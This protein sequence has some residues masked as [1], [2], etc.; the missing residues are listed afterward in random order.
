MVKV[1]EDMTGWIMSEHGF[2][3]SRLSIIRQAEDYI[4]P[5][6]LHY[7]QWWCSCSCGNSGNFIRKGADIRCGDVQSCG[8]LRVDTHKKY[9]RVVLN[10]EDE[11]GEYGIG[12]CSNTDNEFYF[13]MDDYDKIKEYCWYEVDCGEYHTMEAYEKTTQ[14]QIKMHWLIVG[15]HYDHADRNPF[16]NRKYNLRKAT[17]AQNSAN[18]RILKRNTSGFIGLCWEEKRNKWKTSICVNNKRINLGRFDNKED[19]I[20]ARLRAEKEYFGEFAPQ[21]HLFNEYD[22]I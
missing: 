21:Q 20:R 15:K 6:G 1:K 5:Q 8:C 7:A 10:L 3:N 18:R 13:D 2:P 16:N 14:S 22:I 19:A 11:Y 9:N 12:Y 4:T 17:V